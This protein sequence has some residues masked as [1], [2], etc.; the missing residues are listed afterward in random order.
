MHKSF[1]FKG[2][3]GSCD[4]LLAPEG[5]CL[6]LVNLRM[7]N[8]SLRPIPKTVDLAVLDNL[9]SKIYWH[10]HTSCYLCVTD[11]STSTI[12]FYDS[13]WSPLLTSSGKILSFSSLR[14]VRSVEFI[15]TLVC[16]MTDSGIR[17]LISDNG[18]YKWLGERPVPPRLD[19]SV[20]SYLQSMFTDAK[21]RRDSV[22]GEESNAWRLHEKGY[23][24]ECIFNLENKGYF[25]DRSLFK[26]AIR[27][28]DGTYIYC[29]QPF[30]V[31]DDNVLDEVGRDAR[32]M[33]TE[34]V[35]DTAVLSIYKVRVKGFKPE[36]RFSGLNMSNWKGVVAGVDIFTTGSIKGKKVDTVNTTFYNT[37][38]KQYSNVKY[39]KFVAKDIKEIWNEVNDACSF[40]KFAEYDING[41]CL[42]ILED[43]SMT[44]LLLQQSLASSDTSSN[45][46]SIVPA[47]SYV[48]NNRLHLGGI[49]EYFFKGYDKYSFLPVAGARNVIEN[50][51]VEV[52]IKTLNGTSRVVYDYGA[53]ELAYEDGMFEIEPLLTYPDSRAY[54]MT[55]FVVIDTETFKKVLPLT[56]HKYL[57]VSQYLHKWC[58]NYSVKV[59]AAFANGGSAAYISTED[60]LELF[61][62]QVGVH[63]V[64]YSE[65]KNCWLYNEEPFPPKGFEN[66]RIFAFR[67]D[68]ADGDTLKFTI[69]YIAD[70]SGVFAD[71]RNIRVDSAWQSV[72]GQNPYYEEY[73]YEERLNVMKVSPVENPFIFPAKSTFAPSKEKIL[74]I[75]N[76]TF[77]LSQGKFGEHPLFLLCGDGIWAMAVDSSGTV[78]YSASYP[79]S[80]EICR[81]PDSACNVGVG[82]VFVSDKGVMLLS[83][84][85][86]KNI[87]GQLLPDSENC[88]AKTHILPYKDI[89]S[90]ANLSGVSDAFPFLDFVKSCKCAYINSTNE[91]IF[92]NPKKSYSYI[93]SFENGMWSKIDE[94]AEG[95]V[96]DGKSLKMFRH[97]GYETLIKDFGLFIH[98]SN[99]IALFTRPLLWGTKLPKRITELLLHAC[100]E[101][102]PDVE[103][104]SPFFGCYLLCS[105]DGVNF[106]LLK[107]TEVKKPTQDMAFKYF[108]TSSYRY[109]IIA[110]AGDVG[111][112]AMI[113]GVEL[114]I[115]LAWSNRLD[116]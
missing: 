29:S 80:K 34:A 35:D 27:L 28:F 110:L 33:L 62:E 2:I 45:L 61:S 23:I 25:I 95:F 50:F 22:L 17:Y 12:K 6:E 52:K 66:L 90:V 100:I 38:D 82:I 108:P 31:N 71:I 107:G 113:T 24:D 79:I 87:S 43:V 59:E 36:F 8:G 51:T 37:I 94:K 114:D 88:N 19:I 44:N 55:L 14:G 60:V 65:S 18:T 21:F 54:E 42:N 48:F 68:I 69:V 4:K 72:I 116:N 10:G 84:N 40:Y 98:G 39:E 11:D 13:E 109:Y 115:A 53:I 104:F 46:S 74:S 26:F 49:K 5:E 111:E 9:Y 16:C 56:P 70:A 47:C 63:K 1:S 75:C 58:L 89:M 73:P 57:N 67:R 96:Y 41:N 83:G 97:Y 101:L 85:R 103:A 20:T 64:V 105:N 93:Y 7:V 30:Y 78:A 86:I 32:N 15:G 99:R 112:N 81:N 3:G 77:E 102:N 106:K 92:S 91:I 76:N